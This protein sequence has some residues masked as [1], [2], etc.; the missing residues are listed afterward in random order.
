AV[1]RLAILR[2]LV[3]LGMLDEA[4]VEAHRPAQPPEVLQLYDVI[5][6]EDLGDQFSREW[7][8]FDAV[9]AGQPIGTRASGE[10]VLASSDGRIVFP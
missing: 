4:V 2:T 5:D 6:R 10:A 3:F 8:S 1:A 9:T 7:A